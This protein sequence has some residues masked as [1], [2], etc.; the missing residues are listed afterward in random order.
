LIPFQNL[1]T[2]VQDEEVSS[3][4]TQLANYPNPFHYS[5]T[6]T[7]TL[8]EPGY[9]SLAIYDAMGNK[10]DVL[11]DGKFFGAG[12]HSLIFDP[13]H[14]ATGIYILKVLHKGRAITSLM[15]KQ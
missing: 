10:T 1:V 12:K 3:D 5:T 7:F 14:L 15:C 9:T 13:S 11:V 4:I 6:I 8:N 2:S